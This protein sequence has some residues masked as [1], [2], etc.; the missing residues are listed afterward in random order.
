MNAHSTYVVVF[1]KVHFQK[2]VRCMSLSFK[3]TFLSE[4]L[5]YVSVFQKVHFQKKVS[6][7]YVSVFQKYIFKRKFAVC[8]C[9]SKS[10]VHCQVK[11]HCMSVFF[12]KYIFKRKFAVCQCLSKS[13]FSRESLLYVTYFQKVHFW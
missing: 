10:T 3:S 2:K 6:C 7:M 13:T 9:L 4:S 11:V 5:L 8:Q 12:K 1:Q